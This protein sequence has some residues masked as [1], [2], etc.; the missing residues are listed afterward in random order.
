[1][2]SLVNSTKHSKMFNT[3]PSNVF[4]K[5][6]E[7]T[8]LPNS[9]YEVKITLVSKP[10]KDNIKKE[11]YRYISLLTIDAKILKN[12]LANQIQKYI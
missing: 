11:N 3:Y 9:F 2:T 6:E 7:G 4:Q 5:Y 12:T 1:M 10:S 8:I